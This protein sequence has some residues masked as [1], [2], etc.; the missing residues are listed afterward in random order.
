MIPRPQASIIMQG[1]GIH[2]QNVYGTDF[3]NDG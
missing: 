1:K 3:T 2:Y